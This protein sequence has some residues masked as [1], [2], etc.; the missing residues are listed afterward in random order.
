[1][2]LPNLKCQKSIGWGE[3]CFKAFEDLKEILVLLMKSPTCCP[4]YSPVVKRSRVRLSQNLGFTVHELCKWPWI[5]C[6]G[7]EPPFFVYKRIIIYGPHSYCDNET[8]NVKH[9]EECQRLTRNVITFTLFI[10]FFTIKWNCS[11]KVTRVTAS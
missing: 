8:I 7:F 4:V 6:L 1:M 2:Q 11:T 9:L 5:N 3:N 10:F